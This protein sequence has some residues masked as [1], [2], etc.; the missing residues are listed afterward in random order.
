MREVISSLLSFICKTPHVSI[1]NYS[2]RMKWGLDF[3]I[4]HI[5][6]DIL[7]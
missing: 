2:E 3:E 7:E 4:S 6:F 5:L 1:I